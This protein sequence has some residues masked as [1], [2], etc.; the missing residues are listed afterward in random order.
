MLTADYHLK[1]IDFGTAYFFN[2]NLMNKELIE[3][4]NK[5][6]NAEKHDE[7]D[8][9]VDPNPTSRKATFVGTAE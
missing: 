7:D 3:Q 2:T 9:L 8:I 4:I 1:V 5:I 6:K